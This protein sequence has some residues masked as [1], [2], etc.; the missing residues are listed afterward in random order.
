MF[1]QQDSSSLL[2]NLHVEQ[3]H[4]V[5]LKSSSSGRS[6]AMIFIVSFGLTIAEF[7][8][9]DIVVDVNIADANGS[10]GICE[11][12]CGGKSTTYHA[13]LELE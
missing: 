8:M 4:S 10:N 2:R 6:A 7:M 1:W 13:D 3:V 9:D 12:E 11:L 5:G